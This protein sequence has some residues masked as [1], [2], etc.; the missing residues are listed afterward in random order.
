MEKIL[1]V[2][3]DLEIVTR[4]IKDNFN[5]EIFD[6]KRNK[7]IVEGRLICAKL[8]HSAGYTYTSIG[9]A[10]KRDHSSIIYYV[11]T[12]NNLVIQPNELRYKYHQCKDI[13]FK[14]SN[15]LL[16]KINRT[17]YADE[18][19]LLRKQLH[20]LSNNVH[21]LSSFYDKYKRLEDIVLL[22]NERTEFGKEDEVRK[23]IMR[24]FNTIEK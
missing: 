8:L 5:V 13:Y 17:H 14:E 21:R 4:I 19:L 10:M 15:D 3:T 9:K 7:E 2:N 11:K 18:V 12:L 6:K 22:V 20:N 24:M 16:D 23:R 1:D